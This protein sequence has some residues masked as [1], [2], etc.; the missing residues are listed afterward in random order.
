MRWFSMGV[1]I[2]DLAAPAQFFGHLGAP[3]YEFALASAEAGAVRTSSGFEVMVERGARTIAKAD[4][5]VSRA[6]AAPTNARPRR[7]SMRCAEPRRTGPA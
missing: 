1:L 2:L 3:H 7:Y 5:V 4:T 6:I